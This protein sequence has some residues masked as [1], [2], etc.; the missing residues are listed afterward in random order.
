MIFPYHS[1]V[2]S[3]LHDIGVIKICNEIVPKLSFFL[4]LDN[5]ELSHF[6]LAIARARASLSRRNHFIRHFDRVILRI[7]LIF[8]KNRNACGTVT[9]IT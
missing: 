3:V 9:C 5:D 6:Q 1:I 7:A 4:L 8:R 2:Y